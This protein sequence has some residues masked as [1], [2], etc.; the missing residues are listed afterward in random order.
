VHRFYAAVNDAVQ[1]GD[2]ALLESVVAAEVLDAPAGAAASSPCSL[3]CRVA[4]LH[5][6]APHLRL[7]VDEV[8][9]DGDQVAVRLTV[10]GEDQSRFLGLPLVGALAPWGSVDLLR[11]AHGRI[12]AMQPAVETPVIE[13][14]LKMD[15]DRLPLTPYRLGL[16]RLTLHPGATMPRHSV[17]GPLALLVEHGTLAV[18]VD[19]PVV[20][21]LPEGS[22]PADELNRP[23][24]GLTL[25]AGEQLTLDADTAYALRNPGQE[26]VSVLA[27]AAL[28]GDSGIT[29][30]WVR[31]STMAEML[32]APGMLTSVTQTEP[33]PAW[34]AGV[35]GE[36][37]AD[38]IVGV[39]H[40]SSSRITLTRLT[41]SPHAM[42]PIHEA[43]DVEMIALESGTAVVDLVGGE[44]AI[45]PRATAT[46]VDLGPDRGGATQDR[47]ISPGGDAIFQPGAFAGLRNV[48]DDPLILLMLTLDSG[49]HPT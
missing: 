41:L 12:V 19:Q 9:V 43:A 37:L 20:I 31:P 26:T 24:G 42:L 1:T 49:S 35:R 13:P 22:S 46:R 29:N 15:G 44:G 25:A 23:A 11:I 47:S 40:A 45:R 6:L 33:P 48:A 3:R 16:V 10:Q 38:G 28:P 17:A 39:R 2:L 7:A 4:A 8:L 34:P 18:D 36:M 30:R 27:V 32:F 21:D 5:H 14:L